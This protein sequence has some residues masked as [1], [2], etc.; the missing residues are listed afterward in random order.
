[1]QANQAGNAQ[2]AAA[3]PV[4]QSFIVN[5]AATTVVWS[6]PAAITYGTPL[7][8]AQLNATVTPSAAGAFLYTPQLGA[9]V[10]GGSQTLSVQFTPTDSNYAPSSASVT[11]Q[12]NQ[13]SQTITFPPIP[14][15]TYGT[16]PVTLSATGSSALSVTY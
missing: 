4:S 3:T 6:T 9:V 13:A 16:G 14:T 5:P 7:S 2:Y 10:N 8:A 15:Q 11:L 12:V 1:V